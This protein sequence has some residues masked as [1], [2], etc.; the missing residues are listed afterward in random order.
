VR[1][2]KRAARIARFDVRLVP[3]E[4]G[5]AGN[6]G[7]LVDGQ[8]V[9]F[10][11]AY[12]FKRSGADNVALHVEFADA[13]ERR[14][15]RRLVH[16]SSVAVY[17][18]WPSGTLDERSPRD[19]RGSEYKIAKRAIE[20]D[21][22]RRAAAG[23]LSSAILQPTIVYGAFSAQW[24]DRFV[25]RV[26][27]GVVELPGDGLGT[28]SGVYV[29]DVVDALMAAAVRPDAG[30]ATWIISGARPFD[31][32]TL[33]GGCADALGRALEYGDAQGEAPARSRVGAIIN[34]PLRIA[35]WA[36]VHRMLAILRDRLGDER[37][38]RLRERVVALRARGG[39]S[40]YRPADD[41]PSLY[42]ARGV[43]SI[44][45]ARREL[46]FTP[47]FEIDEGMRR[48]RDYIRWRYLAAAAD[49]GDSQSG[50]E[51]TA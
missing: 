41:D 46:N 14:G 31:W 26:R 22:A 1:N 9:A 36:P 27:D 13:C 17:D 8:D 21:L 19:A 47:A 28:C 45:K 49:A 12:D 25:A 35:N 6:V 11:L 30:D 33:I 32:V 37:V 48:T 44:E 40:V 18:D 38:E 43:C 2:L 7:D 5:R 20:I 10:G 15:V 39:P 29:D 4:L 34:D 50:G 23:A 51:S 24:T 42:L 3:I 16:L